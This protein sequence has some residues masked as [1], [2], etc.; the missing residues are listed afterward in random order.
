MTSAPTV[1]TLLR[2]W[3]S[4]DPGALDQLMPLIYDDLRRI[5]GS[6]MRSERAGHTLQATALV[7][8]SFARLAESGVSFQNKAHFFAIASRTM[9]HI[10]TD[11]GRARR[12]QKRGGGVAPVTLQEERV[13]RPAGP[14][15]LVLDD[16][17]RKLAEID[18]RKSD[19]VV[20]HYFGG[21]TYKETAEALNV[22]P[23]TIE[24]DLSLA[25]AWLANE[26]Q[27]D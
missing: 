7:N 11:Y 6:Y 1:T 5:A 14:D 8:E 15:I 10:L 23:A 13:A 3:R 25:K 12:S 26:F 16:A 21:M 4:G 9:R 27:D 22:S 19:V 2:D 17:L 20:L 18:E 24:R